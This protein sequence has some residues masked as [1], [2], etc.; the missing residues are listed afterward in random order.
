MRRARILVTLIVLLD[1]L[2]VAAYLW[3]TQTIITGNAG[4]PPYDVGIVFYADFDA[5]GGLGD[6]SRRRTDAA[7]A[8]FTSGVVPKLLAIGGRRRHPERFG[9][10]LVGERLKK[11]AVPADAITVDRVSFDTVGNWQ[12]AT[13]LMQ[14]Q[15]LQRPL[16][17][18]SALHL[19]RIR[20]IAARPFAI[21]L[22]PSQPLTQALRERPFST[23]LDVHREW[24]AWAAMALLPAQTHRDL[25]QRWRNFWH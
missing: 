12:Q 22:A 24:L 6:E 3:W 9:S 13:T 19:A 2:L 16:L 4:Q 5:D 8:L 11:L 10:A 15:G 23:W 14:E 7:A 1:L 21:T 25:V 18:S 17:I 20:H